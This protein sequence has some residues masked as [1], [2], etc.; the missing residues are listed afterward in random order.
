MTL[1]DTSGREIRVIDETAAEYHAI[2]IILLNDKHGTEVENIKSTG[3]KGKSIII[4]IYKK[5]MKQDTEYS[6]IKLI[7][8]FRQCGLQR[9]AKSLEQH[10]EL[11]GT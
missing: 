8:C 1:P 11:T 4:E 9:L 5:W 2:G 3:E 10:F 6:W 7:K